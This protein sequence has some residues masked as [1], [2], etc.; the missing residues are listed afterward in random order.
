[1]IREN[2]EP[3]WRS[4]DRGVPLYCMDTNHIENSIR[5]CK[6]QFDK[7]GA[8]YFEGWIA[9]FEEELLV[10]K[11]ED[12]IKTALMTIPERLETRRAIRLLLGLPAMMPRHPED[13][14][15]EFTKFDKPKRSLFD[16]TTE[17][18]QKRA[19]RSAESAK[20]ALGRVFGS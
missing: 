6:K 20:A 3:I 13:I 5:F 16:A 4:Q 9:L 19:K 7:S 15:I 2:Y 17:V 14:G 8:S 12:P 1:M 11:Q 18:D 10:R